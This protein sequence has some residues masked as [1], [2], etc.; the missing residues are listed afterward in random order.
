M[1]DQYVDSGR[2][3]K[4][5]IYSL[6]LAGLG[7]GKFARLW[8]CTTSDRVPHSRREVTVYRHGCEIQHAMALA[9]TPSDR[10]GPNRTLSP[11]RCTLG[12]LGLS[13]STSKSRTQSDGVWWETRDEPRSDCCY[14]CTVVWQGRGA[15]LCCAVRAAAQ[16]VSCVLVGNLTQV[17]LTAFGIMTS[18]HTVPTVL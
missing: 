6:L 18:Q 3:K 16:L 11:P 14:Y 17:R 8:Y 10:T 1:L 9:L 2:L 15:V 5:Y 13:L 12:G 7:S 4:L